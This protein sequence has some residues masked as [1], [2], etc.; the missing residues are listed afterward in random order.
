[1]KVQPRDLSLMLALAR[2]GVLSTNQIVA[3]IFSD[4][5][6]TTVLR[7]LRLLQ[8][9][10][11]IIRCGH[12]ASGEKVWSLSKAGAS[13]IN[14]AEPFRFS[15]QNTLYH[16]TCVSE[17]R[18]TLESISIGHDWTSEQE[19]KRSLNYKHDGIVPDGLFVS[20][21]VGEGKV[22]AVELE[23]TAKSH[24]RYRNLFLDYSAISAVEVIWY[25]VKDASITK[26][27]LKLWHVVK[28]RRGAKH[29]QQLLISHFD[30]LL[31]RKSEAEIFDENLSSKRFELV[32]TE[33]ESRQG[34]STYNKPR[35]SSSELNVSDTN[36]ELISAPAAA[37][38]VPSVLDSSLTT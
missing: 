31:Q 4:T 32:F 36:Q 23:F 19:M 8:D 35:M 5:A 14:S 24:K 11:L 30:D 6:V 13:L 26:P 28:Q 15:N 7:R 2:Y 10:V 22:V 34:L 21:I 3:N 37:S 33:A 29:T 18:M 1:M 16:D 12:L 38:G 20:E 27:L 25:I 17:V 9:A